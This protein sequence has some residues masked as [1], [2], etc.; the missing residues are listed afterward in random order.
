MTLKIQTWQWCS[1]LIVVWLLFELPFLHADP[2]INLSF[3]RDAFTDEGLMTSQLRNSINHGILNPLECDNYIKTPLFNL[4]LL[5]PF[6]IFG[7]RL[8]VARLAVLFFVL[9][10][11][12]LFLRYGY[13]Q[14]ILLCFIPV[15]LFQYDLFQYAHFGL[16]E[17]MSACCIFIGIL[18]AMEFSATG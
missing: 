10:A 14:K 13:S 18:Y 16:S 17:M 1:A 7:T 12:F 5:L 9:S 6:K 3:S 8:E 15:A 4:W 2:D 11:L